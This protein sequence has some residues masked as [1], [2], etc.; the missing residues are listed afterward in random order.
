MSKRG[1]YM[2]AEIEKMLDSYE[3]GSLSRRQLVVGLAAAASLPTSAQAPSTLQAVS[4]NHVTLSVSDVERSRQ[5]YEKL[6]G[7]RVVS[8]Q[9]G[10][11]NV[12]AGPDS[13]V[14]LFRIN[15]A[16]GINHFC[17]SAE[18]FQLDAAVKALDQQGVKSRVRDR[19]GVKELYLQDPDGI[20]VQVQEKRYRG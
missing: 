12:G 14:G 5:F 7:M 18:N 13:F 8:K 4:L 19:D 11:I 20:T 17:L 2:I 1:R 10:G 3:R 6:F 9:A 15:G 16:P